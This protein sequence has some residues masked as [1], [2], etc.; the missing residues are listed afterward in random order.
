MLNDKSEI[1]KVQ[2][3]NLIL[4]FIRICK[5]KLLVKKLETFLMKF[6]ESIKEYCNHLDINIDKNTKDSKIWV[7]PKYKNDS[8]NIELFQIL[9]FC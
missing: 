2:S 1:R 7:L 5:S 9:D 6:F 3:L 4:F 8:V